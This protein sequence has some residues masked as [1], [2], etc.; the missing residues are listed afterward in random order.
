MISYFFQR[1]TPSG[2]GHHP[3]NLATQKEAPGSA[4]IQ[5][6]DHIVRAAARLRCS[7]SNA[8]D[9][10]LKFA[11]RWAG[12]RSRICVRSGTRRVPESPSSGHCCPARRPKSTSQTGVSCSELWSW[13]N[14]KRPRRI[15]RPC[16]DHR[17]QTRR[18]RTTPG[19][20]IAELPS[21]P[22]QATTRSC[23]LLRLRYL[24]SGCQR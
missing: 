2:T 21:A 11:I 13:R 16:C 22:R 3:S 14:R 15:N 19:L 6:G 8:R 10:R 9:S 18:R 20:L 23:R 4:G 7:L 24:R 5:P 17:N 12:S 1:T